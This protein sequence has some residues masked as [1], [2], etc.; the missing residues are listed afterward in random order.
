MNRPI[1]DISIIVTCY[2]QET[3][4]NETLD[5]VFRQTFP[6]WECLIIDDGS[7]DNSKQIAEKWCERD[8]RFKYYFQENTGVSG[9]RNT[10]IQQSKGRFIQFLDGDDLLLKDKLDASSELFEQNSISDIVIT[11]FK[12]Y[13]ERV[14]IYKNSYCNLRTEHFNFKNILLRWDEDFSI[15]IHCALFKK[16]LFADFQFPKTLKAKEDWFMWVVI[17]KNHPKV[18][19]LEK[20]LVIYRAHSKSISRSTDMKHDHL[21]ALEFLKMEL[22]HEDYEILL[23]RFIERY[24]NRSLR[25]K[26]ELGA[27][28]SSFWFKVFDFFQKIKVKLGSL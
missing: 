15:P 26:K 4:L 5:S 23:K 11:D 28:R 20:E 25:F 19:Y 17:F 12:I 13:D 14:S 1:P 24:Y 27:F 10:G 21:K 7:S 22:S 9:A 16:K 18:K 2:N 3:F 8:K 6:D